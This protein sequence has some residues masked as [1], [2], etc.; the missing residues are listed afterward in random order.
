MR[1]ILFF[2]LG[3]FITGCGGEDCDQLID[4]GCYSFDIRQCQT[5]AFANV[6]SENDNVVKREEDLKQWM[7]NQGL[8]IEDVKLVTNF[9]EVVCEACHV[10]PQGDRYYIKLMF[11]PA[12]DS[13][14]LLNLEEADCC[15][16]F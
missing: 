4:T 15:D 8:F 11:Q 13:L 10:C 7:E 9:H 14:D 2:A 5:D 1:L 3:L 6:V 12:L 16:H